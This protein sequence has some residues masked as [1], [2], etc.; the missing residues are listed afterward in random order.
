MRITLSIDGEA[1]AM[2]AR[3]ILDTLYG[4]AS[5]VPI[6]KQPSAQ[7]AFGPLPSDLPAPPPLPGPPEPPPL[8]GPPPAPDTIPAP[9]LPATPPPGPPS[10]PPP[11]PTP[12]EAPAEKLDS[13]GHIWNA[14]LHAKSKTK[15]KDGTWRKKRG[16]T[17]EEIDGFYAARPSAA[18]VPPTPIPAPPVDTTPTPPVDVP[19]APPVDV[20]LAAN[21]VAWETV[22]AVFQARAAK[23]DN[24]VL[25]AALVEVGID[26]VELPRHPE[27]FA[28]A[29]ST[30]ESKCPM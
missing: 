29:L 17:Q 14:A 8:P 16:V 26:P 5:V 12:G 22:M 24:D 20:P 21:S 13:A 27:Q 18:V 23:Y 3:Q 19:P 9:P 6:Q 15:V 10:T 11:P 28:L 4:P 1:D 30:L 2:E 25:R 7:E